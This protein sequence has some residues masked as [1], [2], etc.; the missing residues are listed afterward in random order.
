MK[1]KVH[2]YPRSNGDGS[3]SVLFFRSKADADAYEQAEAEK[4]YGEPWGESCARTKVLEFD[5]K[6]NLLNPDEDR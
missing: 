6:G 2:Y 4:P 1:V 5:D 3:V